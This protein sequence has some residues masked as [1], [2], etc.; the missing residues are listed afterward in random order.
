M[1]INRI[2]TEWA[3]NMKKVKILEVTS[4][5]KMNITSKP[6]KMDNTMKKIIIS[7]LLI[8][9]PNMTI[10]VKIHR[11]IIISKWTMDRARIT[12]LT[13]W[14]RIYRHT[15]LGLMIMSRTIN[16]RIVN[17]Q[18]TQLINKLLILILQKEKRSIK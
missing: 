13:I 3:M 2:N 9:M 15:I 12:K 5:M 17:T 14:V 11:E 7:L 6:E 4:D 18:L 16:S 8:D 10:M 1:R